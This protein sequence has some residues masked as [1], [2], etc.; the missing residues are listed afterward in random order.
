MRCKHCK[1]TI[2]EYQQTRTIPLGKVHIECWDDYVKDVFK[3]IKEKKKN[4]K[5]EMK[6]A[7]S[8]NKMSKAKARAK[9]SFNRFIRYRDKDKGCIICGKHLVFGSKSYHAGHY[10]S[11]GSRSD[12][13]FEETNCFGECSQCN[14]YNPSEAHKNHKQAVIARIGKVKEAKLEKRR[15]IK[16]NLKFYQDIVKKY[17]R[18][19]RELKKKIQ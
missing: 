5:V 3:K 6:K 19:F 8:E 15:Y 13:E 16:K 2:K 7:K 1:K 12:L 17:N 11:V 18:K 4:I 14:L 10:H 9:Y